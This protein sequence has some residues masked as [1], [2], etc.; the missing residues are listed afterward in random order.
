MLEKAEVAQLLYRYIISTQSFI[1]FVH[2]YTGE[3]VL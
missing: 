2:V 1:T 3:T